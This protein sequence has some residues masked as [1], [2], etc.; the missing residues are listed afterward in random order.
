L[1]ELKRQLQELVNQTLGKRVIEEVIITGLS[2]DWAASPAPSAPVSNA[3]GAVGAVEPQR[4]DP[5]A[6]Y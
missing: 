6:S 5:G 4:K 1:T 3:G 2:I